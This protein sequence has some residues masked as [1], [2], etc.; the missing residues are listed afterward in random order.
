M[1]LVKESQIIFV[2]FRLIWRKFYP[3]AIM[4]EVQMEITIRV[5]D[6]KKAKAVLRLLE[7][8]SVID[9]QGPQRDS[10]H[11]EFEAIFGIWKD[12]DIS[13]HALRNEAWRLESR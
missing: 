9:I 2:D 5:K 4:P 6:E 7:E 10:S 1:A 12:R 8:L 13:A 3:M 11:K